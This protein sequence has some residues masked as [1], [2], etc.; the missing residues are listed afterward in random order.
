[1]AHAERI[2]GRHGRLQAAITGDR[3]HLQSFN[4]A[5]SYCFRAMNIFIRF[6]IRFFELMLNL[7]GLVGNGSGYMQEH[8][9]TAE[10]Q[11]AD[12]GECCVE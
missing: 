10:V 11:F 12:A 5:G 7:A 8:F 1:M 2:A 6:H 9:P 3:Y 4:G